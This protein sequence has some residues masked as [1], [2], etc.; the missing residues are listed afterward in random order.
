MTVRALEEEI[1]KHN[2]L[3]AIKELFIKKIQDRIDYLILEEKCKDIERM[4]LEELVALDGQIK[5]FEFN[6]N[7]KEGYLTKI[8]FYIQKIKSHD[9]IDLITKFNRQNRKYTSDKVYVN[10]GNEKFINIFNKCVKTEIY[11]K[12][13]EVPLMVLI[14]NNNFIAITDKTM[15]CNDKSIAIKNIKKIVGEKLLFIGSIIIEAD[16]STKISIQSDKNT[17]QKDAELLNNFVKLL[18]E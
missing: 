18:L 10:N 1:S 14:Y 16:D 8:E 2:Y 6:N 5:E 4:T 15:Y 17:V 12:K 3:E 9:I 13:Y 11:S 7:I